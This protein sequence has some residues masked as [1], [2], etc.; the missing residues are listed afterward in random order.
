MGNSNVQNNRGAFNLR[1]AAEFIGTN[2]TTMC[3]LVQT[4]GFPAFRLGRRWIIPRS[5][6][7]AWLDARAAE[8]AELDC[9]VE[10]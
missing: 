1:E 2:H 5:A 4:P 6:L 7:V 10:K 8:R 3:S 9:G